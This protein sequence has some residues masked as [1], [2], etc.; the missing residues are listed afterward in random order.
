MKQV[1][2]ADCA[3]IDFV[4]K[5]IDAQ[6]RDGVR[7]LYD[8]LPDPTVKVLSHPSAN[9]I[10]VSV[11]SVAPRHEL[12]HLNGVTFDV[13]PQREQDETISLTRVVNTWRVATVKVTS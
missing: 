7:I 3:C 4:Q 8:P 12:R 6:R 9:A 13:I 1:A 5:A 10:V 11:V 2:L